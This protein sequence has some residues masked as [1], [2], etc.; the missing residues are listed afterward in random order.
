MRNGQHKYNNAKTEDNIGNQINNDNNHNGYNDNRTNSEYPKTSHLQHSPSL[1][2]LNDHKFTAKPSRHA[3]IQRNSI[4][5]LNTNNNM[6]NTNNESHT[7]PNL[8]IQKNQKAPQKPA[9]QKK[10]TVQKK[11]EAP[12]IVY[13][14]LDYLNTFDDTNNIISAFKPHHPIIYYFKEMEHFA[15]SYYDLR[16]KIRDYF[17][18]PMKQA[19]D[20]VEQNVKDCLK[21]INELRTLMTQLENP[22]NYNDISNQYAE[23]VKEYKKEI[24]DMQNCLKDNYKQNFKAILS[25]K[26]KMNLALKDIYASWWSQLSSTDTYYDMVKRYV[27]EVNKFD[28]NTSTSFMD[29]IKKI[30]NSAIDTMKKMKEELNTSLD[31]DRVEFIIEEI[32]HMVEKFNL[33]LS[34]MRYGADYIKNIDSQKIESYV[35]QVELRTLFYVAAKHYADFKFSLEHLKMFENL[36][37]SKEKML[38]STFE[39]LEG[40]L[41]NKINTLMGSEQSTSD[42]TSIIADSEK[43]IKSAESLINSS[44]EEIAKYALD[45]NEKINEIKK[46]YDQKILSVKEFI[47]KSNGLITT[48]KGTSKL[49]ESDKKQIDKKIEKVKKNTNTLERGNEF[50]KIM[51]EVKTKISNSSNSAT[52]SKDFSHKLKELQTEFEGL[53]KTIE[54]DLQKIK[55]IKVKEDEDR[56]MKN[57]I[58]EHLKYASDNSDKVKK[59]ISKNNEIQNYIQKIENLIKDAPSGKEKF[60]TQKTDL[61]NKVKTIIDEFHKEDLQL[62]LNSLSTFYEEHQKLYREAST[63][64][65]I[66]ELHPKIKEEYEKL[67]KKN[68]SNIDQ[69]LHNLDAELDKLKA[70]EKNIVEEQTNNINKDMTDSLNKLTAEVNSLRSALDSY[71]A[72][73]GHLKTYKNQI[74]ERKEKFLST[75]KEQEDD[76]PD[77]KNIYEEYNK[78]KGVMDNKEQKIT[79]DI[80]QCREN[81]KNAEKNREK[82]NTL[83]QTLEA[84]TGE[85]DP[86]VHDSLEKFKTNLE[87]LNLSKLETEFKSL[88]D[89]A[90]TT[91]KQIENIIKNI[92][93]IKSLNFTKNSSDSSKLSLE[94]IKENKADLIK[95]LEQHT[96]EI[97]KYTF[98]EKEETLPL[99]SDLRE[100]K[101]RVQRDMSEELISQLNTKINAILEYYDK[102]KDSFN[103]DDETKLEQLDE[104]KKECQYV[105]QE[106]EKLTTNYKVLE[107]KINDIINEQHEKVITLSENHITGKDKK[108]NEKIQQNINSLND[109][110]TKLGLLEIN[111]DIKNSKDA[112]IKNKIQEFENKVKTI[113]GN[114]DKANNKIDE[115]KRV[116]VENKVAFDKEKVENTNFEKKKK[117]IE[118][119]YEQMEKTIKELEEMNDESNIAKEVEEAQIQYKRIFID[120]DVNLM[121]DEVEKSKTVMEEIELYKKEIDQIKKKMIEYNKADT[122]NFDYTVPYNSAT[123]SKAKIEQF[124]TNAKTKKGTSDASQDI[125]E[126]ERI[127]EEVHTN[128]QQV[129]L[130]NNSMEEKRKQIHN[131]KNLLILNNSETI[132]KEI[133]N[134]TQNALNFSLDAKKEL[135][136]TDELLQSVEAKIAEAEAHKKKID[137]ALEDGQIDTE[138]SKIEQINQE[139]MNKRDEIKSYLSEIKKYKEKC[140]TEIS[141][142]KRG[143]DKI[144]FLKIFKPNEDSNRNKVNINEIDGNISKSE[145]YLTDI[146]GTEKQ[147][148]T[149]VELFHNHETNISNI[150]KQ[151][152]ILGVETKSKKKIREADD[153]M[154]EIEGHNSEI[155]T[156]VK[157]FQENLNKLNE[158]HNYDNAE[159]ELNNDKSTSAKVLIQ[160]N[161]ESVKHNLSEITNIKDGG[162]NIYNKANDI[163][164]KI[165][166]I[167]KNSAE[168][169]LDKVKDDH[170]NYVNY[171]DQII[172]ERDLIVTEKNRLNGKDSTIKNIEAAL[173]E[174]K[175]NYE[176]GLLEKLEEIGKNIKLKVDITKESINS[177]VGNFSSLFNNFDLNQY[178]FNNNINDYKKK[179]GEIYNEFEGSLNKISENLRNASEKASDYNLAKTLRQDAQKEKVNLLNK[180]EEANK[181]LRDVKKVESFRFILNMKESLDKINDMIKTEKLTVDEGH[182]NVKQLVENIKDL[183]DENNLSDMLKQ[184]SGKNDEIQKITHS[185]HKNKAKTILGHVDTSAKYVGIKIMPELAL[186]ELLGDSNLKNAQELIFEPKTNVPLETEHMSKNTNELDVY[187][188]IQDAYKVALEILAHSDEIDTKQKD[189]SKLIEMGNEIYLK[190]VLINQYK[191]KISSIK[192]KEEAVSGKIDNVSK[193]HSEL[194]KITCSDK[195]YDNIIALEKQTELQDLR[196]SFT[197]E[198][199]E[200]NSDSKLETITKDFESLKNALK[201][202]E[203]EVNALKASSNDHEY[204]KGK[205]AP[206]NAVQTEMEKTETGIDSLDTALDELLQ[207]G[208]KCEVSRYTLIK[209]TVVKEISDD[210]ELIN[211]IEKNVKAYLAY[212]KKN[213]EDTVQDVLTLNEHFKEKQVSNHEPTNFDKSNKSSEELTKAVTDSKTIISKL[214]GVIIEVNENTEMNTIE[215]S[216]KEIEALYNELKNKKTSLNEIY[217]TSNEVKLQEMKSNADKYIDVSK[218][219]NTVL[220]TQKSNIVTNQH[221]I[222][223]VKDKLKGKLQELIDADSSFTLESIKKFNE[224]YSHIKTNIG[225]LEQLQ[226]TNKSE[227]DN[228]AKHKEK[229]VHLIN[230]VESLKGDVKNHDDDQYMKK[231]NASLLNDNIKNTTNSINISD[232]ELKKLLK[233]VEENDQLC[234]NNNTQNFISDIM[235]RVEDLNRRF[236]EN[237][238]EKEKLHQIENNYNEISS[239]FSEINLQDVDEFVAKIHKQ[240]DAEKASVNNVREAEK[241]RTAIQNVTSYD[242]EI[243]SRLSEM[244]NVLER[245]TTR[246]TKMDQL[247]KS[248]SPDNTSLNL[249]ARTH[250]RKSEDIIKQ[251]NSHIEKITELNTYAHEVMT[252]LENE[253]NKLLKQLEIESAKVEPEALPSDT[254]V[255][256]E[257]VPPTVTENGPQENLTS[258]PQETLEDNT[259][260]IQENVVQEDSVIAPQE[261]VEYSTLAVPEND[262]TT[263]EE[264]EHD[265]AHDDTHDESQTGRDSTAKEAIGKTRLAGAVIIAMSVLSGFIIIVFKDKDEEE[266]D[267]NEHGYN[268]AFG[269]HDE[270]NMHDKEE[271]IEVCFNE[272]D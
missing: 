4:Y 120:H 65:N 184:A 146:K 113:L 174:S 96:Q 33:H 234:K 247:L 157:S 35:Y 117:S 187:K 22:Q 242:T 141:N 217:Q 241:I 222:N 162:E 240:I 16:S 160:T 219:F 246:K 10:P 85:K 14:N 206:I 180:E 28:K 239:I 164:Q 68:Y 190:V 156:Q 83:V 181:Y 70:L 200:T 258:V 235:K 54:D 152:E 38:Y 110:K 175:K 167:S 2:H 189:S 94:K 41:L 11:T 195:T 266:K 185:M 12:E 77:G 86:N 259:P 45:S 231:L 30:H 39:K 261:Q 98:I 23:K 271:V 155:Q 101:N 223:N 220:D 79:S 205:S 91:N 143:K 13:G 131:M 126:L 115:I 84:H 102:S 158:P 6:E 169:T 60:T 225:E 139:I 263:E 7:V 154:K 233:K 111:Q 229:I 72:D 244:N 179:M 150:F 210:T 196:N 20:V 112:T 69:T 238:P 92:D 198:K 194:S 129:K 29:H 44:S 142:S 211:T 140:T 1:V 124:I 272:E 3:Y 218:I 267:H 67:E 61:Q 230:R 27:L 176:I 257:K 132:A 149:N 182:G 197:Q 75:L 192:I 144:E 145:Q 228:V 57:Q 130:E 59:L 250:V 203:G 133:S 251:L 207:K 170:S 177:T 43:I 97:E 74:N 49:S 191:N 265:D 255:K 50:I 226:Q 89:S 99:L 221:S 82:F 88:I 81:I 15:N 66:K 32:G 36:S 216:A 178:D 62:L 202:L 103:G 127:K 186:T 243:I 5:T 253:L 118:K 128:L 151:S 37:K 256:E 134:N 47:N 109:M 173:K 172:T 108:I 56:S 17:A 125:K 121:N 26:L 53:N 116:H 19:F 163:M 42:L 209:D 249:N 8:F 52:N 188:N 264:S 104:F 63:I 227:H 31:S 87:N 78:H 9:T 114:I 119:V 224:I 237:L 55:D 204:V 137:I 245:I 25:A 212:V 270:Y 58:E 171:L 199:T 208:R 105:Q 18:L 262:E 161:L 123:Q 269:E 40:D 268:E 122:S 90:S 232:E 168:K 135:K 71:K 100:E 51:N 73:E 21:N 46:N 165:K 24:E 138:V 80:N 107:N 183:V 76:I 147:A 201:T 193:K 106:I 214:K 64:E 34:K 248:L 48:V 260:Q 236:T 166:A 93:T 148:N 136:K 215:S 159:D 254:E 252:Y 213:Y 153:I 95:K